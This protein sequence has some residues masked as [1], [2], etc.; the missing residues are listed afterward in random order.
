MPDGA[1]KPIR[2]I[3]RTQYSNGFPTEKITEHFK[4]TSRSLQFTD[5]DINNLL[6][7]K[8]SH[9]DTLIILSILYPWADLRNHF[10]I[11]HMHPKSVFTT[12]KLREK[13]VSENQINDFIANHNYI[14]N[15]QLLENIPNIEKNAMGFDEW[16]QEKVSPSEQADYKSKHYIPNVDLSITNFDTFL[17]ER[18]KLLL[19]KLKRELQ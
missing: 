18:E 2:D 14:G 8:Y 3:I 4:G 7:A 11:D 13:G 10:H 5:D 6:Y 17:E 9:G 19:E 12:K 16:L 1:L 15:L